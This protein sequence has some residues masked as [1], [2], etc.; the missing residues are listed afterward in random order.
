MRQS[1]KDFVRKVFREQQRPL[2]TARWAPSERLE[3]NA[4]LNENRVTGD[5]MRKISEGALRGVFRLVVGFMVVAIFWSCA[6]TPPMEVPEADVPDQSVWAEDAESGALTYV[7]LNV[8][9]PGTFEHLALEGTTEYDEDGLDVSVG[10]NS[11]GKPMWLTFYMYL[12]EYYPHADL[13]SHFEAVVGDVLS[14]WPGSE[15][16]SAHNAGFS[17]GETHIDGFLA[18]FRYGQGPT[19]GA[20]GGFAVLFPYG[21][22]YVYMRTSFL[23]VDNQAVTDGVWGTMDRF[24]IELDLTD[25]GIS[26]AD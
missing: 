20:W 1:E 5:V 6:T 9:F 23:G 8:W 26:T 2:L 21:D 22:F 24:L 14:E 15:L 25:P 7:P 3:L 11:T 10:Y 12:K 17:F 18:S 4:L 16:V 13:R 19:P